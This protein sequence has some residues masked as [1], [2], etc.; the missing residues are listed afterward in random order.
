[1]PARSQA[2]GQGGVL[3]EKSVAGVDGVDA[4]LFGQGDDAFDIQVGFHG[5][6]ALADEVGFV[7]LEA[8]QGEAVFLGIDGDGAQAQFIGG[9]E[10]A[11][12]DFATIQCKEF[13]HG[14]R[15]EMR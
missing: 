10:D 4:L 11:D 5:P 1:M 14:R 6:F 9:A 8:V 12:G 7:G 2:R 15:R 3:G 13:F